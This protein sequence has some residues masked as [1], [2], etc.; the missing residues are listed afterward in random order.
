LLAVALFFAVSSTFWL[1][2][3]RDGLGGERCLGHLALGRCV[4]RV[5]CSE[6]VLG[7]RLAGHRKTKEDTSVI[8]AISR[9]K[10]RFS[11]ALDGDEQPSRIN[12]FALPRWV[13]FRSDQFF[14]RK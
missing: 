2:Q 3:C 1:L 8:C 10:G 7:H 13:F 5:K 4:S 12:A 14:V 9:K 6:L 11:L